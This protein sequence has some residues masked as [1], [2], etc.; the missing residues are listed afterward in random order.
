MRLGGPFQERKYKA[1]TLGAV[2]DVQHGKE[3][4]PVGNR[5]GAVFHAFGFSQ[6]RST[7]SEQRSGEST[8]GRK[9]TVP[10]MSGDW[11][12]IRN[13]ICNRYKFTGLQVT[14]WRFRRYCRSRDALR[15]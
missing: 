11:G 7:K 15:L 2:G 14:A 6:I 1:M 9:P 5:I 13:F 3:I 12:A 10:K 8:P 4:R